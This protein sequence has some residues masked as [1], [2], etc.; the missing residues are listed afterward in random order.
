MSRC[1]GSEMDPWMTVHRLS[2]RQQNQKVASELL[3]SLTG[4]L[5]KSEYAM[6]VHEY[7]NLEAKRMHALVMEE[8]AQV[9]PDN[10]SGSGRGGSQLK[11]LQRSTLEVF[12][13]PA[14]ACLIQGVTLT[15]PPTRPASFLKG[16]CN[17]SFGSGSWQ[18]VQMARAA[19]RLNGP[20]S[21][22]TS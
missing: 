1:A 10:V 6:V 12:A 9:P 20:R 11:D 21:W 17:Y 19:T 16:W 14:R 4:D 8:H 2:F 15:A 3:C 7:V 5:P 13:S 22:E 18:M